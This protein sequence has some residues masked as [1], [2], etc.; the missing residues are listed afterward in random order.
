M[1][2][3]NERDWQQDKLLSPYEIAKLKKSGIDIHELKGVRGAS[4][5]DL[6]KDKDGA[7]YIKLKDGL[8]AGEFTGLNINDF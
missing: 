5:K 2:S 3:G 8:G 7:I 6:Y 1:E 4:R